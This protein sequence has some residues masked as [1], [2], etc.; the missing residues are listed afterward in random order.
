MSSSKM[1]SMQSSSMSEESTTINNKKSS[2]MS[3]SSFSEEHYSSSSSKSSAI[4]SSERII[5]VNIF[6]NKII[7]HTNVCLIFLKLIALQYECSFAIF[8]VNTSFNK[9]SFFFFKVYLCYAQNVIF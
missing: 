2:S 7:T 1:Y 8:D 3:Q 5:F 9:K 6:Y 4:D